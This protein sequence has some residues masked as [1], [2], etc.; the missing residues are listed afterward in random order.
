MLLQYVIMRPNLSRNGEIMYV[1]ILLP[2]PPAWPQP[3]TAQV[4]KLCS[5]D[6]MSV[7]HDSEYI[8]WPG[9]VTIIKLARGNHY[10]L[11]RISRILI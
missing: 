10:K 8:S 3:P 11:C 9:D 4:Y 5:N 2:G 6:E 1:L 7:R